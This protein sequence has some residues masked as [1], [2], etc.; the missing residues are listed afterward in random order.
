MSKPTQPNLNE[1]FK[2]QGQ[3]KQPVKTAASQ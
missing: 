2:K 1:F 3:K